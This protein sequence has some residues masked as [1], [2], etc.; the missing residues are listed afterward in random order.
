VCTWRAPGVFAQSSTP[1][2][3]QK[4]LV[5]LADFSDKP[6]ECSR[7][8]VQSVMFDPVTSVAALYR[9]NSLGRI[10]LSGDVVGPYT[11]N[12][13]STD[14]CDLG[15]LSA[16]AEASAAGAGV[17]TS[18]F[19]RRV[20]VLPSNTCPGAGNGTMHSSPSYSWIFA[21]SVRGAYV[22]NLGHNLGFAHAASISTEG[23]SEYGDSGD[24][25]GWA[26][27]ALGGF[28]APHRHQLGWLDSY[29]VETVTAD[30]SF[31]IAPLGLDPTLAAGPQVVMIPKADTKEIYY[32]SYRT[33][34][35]FDT[36]VDGMALRRL[37]IHR[38]KGDGS[39]NKTYLMA[40]LDDGQTFE[41]PAN[42]IVVTMVSHTTGYVRADVKIVAPSCS[43]AAPAVAVTPQTQTAAPGSALTYSI[44]VTNADTGSCPATMF[45]LTASIPAG[46]NST[47]S[48]SSLSLG[49]GVTGSASV[50]VS[51][52]STT[53]GGSYTATIVTGGSTPAHTASGSAT[54]VVQTNEDTE[55]PTAPNGLGAVANRKQKKVQLSWNAAMD[56]RG[57]SG[58]RV[59]RDGVLAALTT[60][61]A[62]TD[63][64]W[65]AGASYT[66][67]VSAYDAAGNVS[68]PSASVV[69]T[70]P[71]GGGKR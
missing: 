18:P 21:C 56:N 25:M 71:G 65:R 44:S 46:W 69:V 45:G 15:V 63:P 6:L 50:T 12:V 58:Y 16:A 51:S 68:A 61:T 3:D 43:A 66:Y 28:N 59:S 31:D 62:W 7:E 29:K 70:L 1:S 36:G 33:P 52:L 4:T 8:F 35:G 26:T 39:M 14:A 13:A 57:V 48:P 40:S 49:P 10:T 47:V 2:G 11:L 55:P 54:Y 41:D 60:T 9:N 67:S 38:Y 17:D 23:E 27:N 20:I 24:P 34:V 53:S 42:G 37:T 19:L 30:G 64:T 5:I 22:H 32:L